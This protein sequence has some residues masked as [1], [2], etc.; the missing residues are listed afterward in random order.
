MDFLVLGFQ[1]ILVTSLEWT[2]VN[3]GTRK[4]MYTGNLMTRKRAP[5]KRE[6]RVVTIPYRTDDGS[7]KEIQ[8]ALNLGEQDATGEVFRTLTPDGTMV[9]ECEITAVKPVVD[10]ADFQEQIEFTMREV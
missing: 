8:D 5:S 2:P 3:I 4:R 6:A 9:V 1:V 7:S 10:G